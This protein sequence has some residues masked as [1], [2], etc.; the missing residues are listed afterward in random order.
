MGFWMI[1]RPWSCLLNASRQVCA[2]HNDLCPWAGTVLSPS[3]T[4]ISIYVWL[5]SFLGS[6]TGRRISFV[7]VDVPC[8]LVFSHFGIV[9]SGLVTDYNFLLRACNMSTA[10]GPYSIAP[11][12]HYMKGNKQSWSWN[13]ELDRATWSHN[14]PRTWCLTG[15]ISNCNLLSINTAT[16]MTTRETTTTPTHLDRF[17]YHHRDNSSNWLFD[18]HG[19]LLVFVLFIC[20]LVYSCL[21]TMYPLQTRKFVDQL[22]LQLHFCNDLLCTAFVSVSY[23]FLCKMIL[24]ANCV[25]FFWHRIFSTVEEPHALVWAPKLCIACTVERTYSTWADGT[26]AV[27]ITDRET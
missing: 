7:S 9:L 15:L 3:N 21:F 23:V 19:S 1:V 10:G 16:T 25:F 14:R 20:S 4:G 8:A 6:A 24:F 2:S 13:L 18:F 12:I 17:H 27:P 11:R 22:Q 5:Y 26:V